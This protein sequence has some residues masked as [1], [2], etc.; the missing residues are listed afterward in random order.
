MA[1]AAATTGLALTCGFGAGAG[2][3]AAVV[4]P[5]E[6]GATAAAGIGLVITNMLDTFSPDRGVAVS[7]L[8]ETLRKP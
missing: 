1:A 6:L 7:E 5:D 2:W 4:R 8:V 3:T